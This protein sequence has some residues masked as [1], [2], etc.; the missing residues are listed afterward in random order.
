M[1]PGYRYQAI[2]AGMLA[3][4]INTGAYQAE[5]FRGGLK[6][7]HEGQ[8]EAGQALGFTPWRVMRHIKLPQTLRLIIPPMTNEFIALLKASALLSAIAIVEMSFVAQHLAVRFFQPIEPWTVVTLLYLSM[9]VPLAKVVQYLEIRFRIPGLGLP[10][11]RA[12]VRRSAPGAPERSMR[13]AKALP[14]RRRNLLYEGLVARMRATA[15]DV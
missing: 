2:L 11:E 12:F 1:T 3:L 13:G 10:T 6:A 5:I 4:T 8:I 14:D 9:T 7:I 15:K